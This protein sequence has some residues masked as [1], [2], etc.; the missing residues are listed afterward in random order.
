M[1]DERLAAA[2]ACAGKR[3][4]QGLCE[5]LVNPYAQTIAR[6]VGPKYTLVSHLT[7]QPPPPSRP[8]HFNQE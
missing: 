7:F 4:V 3:L 8:R 6:E 5:P 1:S 2:A